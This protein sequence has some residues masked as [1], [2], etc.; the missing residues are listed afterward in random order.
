M[1]RPRESDARDN[2]SAQT[3]ARAPQITSTGSRFNPIRFTVTA[4]LDSLGRRSVG[5]CTVRFRS[6]TFTGWQGDADFR[7]RKRPAIVLVFRPWHNFRL[8]HSRARF[9]NLEKQGYVTCAADDQSRD[10]W[11]GL[12]TRCGV[13][14]GGEMDPWFGIVTSSQQR[15]LVIGIIV[16]SD[17]SMTA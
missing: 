12:H 1:L 11:E 9:K 16:S 13:T 5:E 3:T 4:F 6:A 15:P 7:P 2:P 14:S 8:E 10:V 17:D